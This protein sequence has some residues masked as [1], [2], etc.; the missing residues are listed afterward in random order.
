M[1]IMS[2]QMAFVDGFNKGE[3]REEAEDVLKRTPGQRET[4]SELLKFWLVLQT[5][6]ETQMNEVE[7]SGESL[8]CSLRREWSGIVRIS[9]K[10]QT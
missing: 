3:R 2:R 4:A 6:R 7:Y 10:G 8:W 1:E 5:S 9:H